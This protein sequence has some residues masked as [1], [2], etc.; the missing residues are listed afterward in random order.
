MCTEWWCFGETDFESVAR[1]PFTSNS[2]VLLSTLLRECSTHWDSVCIVQANSWASFPSNFLFWGN[3][4]VSRSSATSRLRVSNYPVD[5]R[6]SG[7]SSGK[8]EACY[9]CTQSDG[10]ILSVCLWECHSSS[11]I[12]RDIPLEIHLSKDGRHDF[13]S[14]W[15]TWGTYLFFFC[16]IT[17]YGF[18]KNP[19]KDNQQSQR[20]HKG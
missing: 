20:W 4:W 16:V 6:S 11:C 9:V 5:S 3:A 14:S 18:E 2:S 12:F 7:L 13:S 8:K 17:D 19:Q 15:V 10:V 1:I